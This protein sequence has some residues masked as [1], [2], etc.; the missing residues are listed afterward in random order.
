MT[1]NYRVLIFDKSNMT[2][3]IQFEGYAPLNYAL[4]IV[5]GKLPTGEIW[6]FWVQSLKDHHIDSRSED[7]ASVQDTSFIESIV[8]ITP[9]PYDLPDPSLYGPIELTDPTT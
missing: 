4:P 8:N 3:T 1:M 5:D 2:A 7:I 6:E 9:F